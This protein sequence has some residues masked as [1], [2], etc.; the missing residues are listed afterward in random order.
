MHQNDGILSTGRLRYWDGGPKQAPVILLLHSAFSDAAFSWSP[1]WEALAARNRVIAPDMPGFGASQA[2]E[3][4]SLATLAGALR[5]LL[6]QLGVARATVVGN[7]FGVSA[8][9][10]LANLYPDCVERLVLVNGV[11]LPPVSGLV[12]RATAIPA[13]RSR[14]LGDV[15]SRRLQPQGDPGLVPPCLARGAFQDLRSNRPGRPRELQDRQGLRPQLGTNQALGRGAGEPALG[16]GRPA[17]ADRTGARSV[18]GSPRRRT[19]RHRAGRPSAP[20]GSAA[21][22][23]RSTV[24]VCGEA[25]NFEHAFL[26]RLGVEAIED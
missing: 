18:Q 26:G 15:L 3:R 17:Y 14:D 6:G 9:I 16:R 19:R 21:G 7:S 22:V 5:E 25:L 20:A 11:M 23:R 2:P 10:S 13:D 12:K 8:A 24:A 4:M 1:V